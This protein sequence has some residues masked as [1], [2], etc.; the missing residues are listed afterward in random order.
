MHDSNGTAKHLLSR[1]FGQPSGLFGRL[2]G[3]IMSRE[4][5]QMARRAIRVL[6]VRPDDQVLEVGCGPGV[7]IRLL[8]RSAPGVIAVGI[9]PSEEMLE[10]ARAR[11]ATA[12]RAGRVLLRQA[13]AEELPFDDAAFDRAF[14]I[15]SM[16]LWSD[17][18]A[19][20]RELRR[21]LKPQG[22]LVLGLTDR[23]GQS[24][25]RLLALLSVCG[26]AQPEVISYPKQGQV[27]A[28]GQ[29]GD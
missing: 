12:V 16:S 14:A 26:F 10:Q 3:F 9:D 6:H 21:V 28:A 1:T 13:P 11:N 20:L 25:R 23:S 24:E 7:A 22:R 29:A 15:R 8:L 4:N 18:R 19:G 5:R 17:S 27:F 2:G